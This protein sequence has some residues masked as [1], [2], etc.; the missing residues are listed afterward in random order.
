MDLNNAFIY[1]PFA[2]ERDF[3]AL[4]SLLHNVELID[5]SN[6]DVSEAT[7]REQLTWTGHNPALDR[8]VAYF[9]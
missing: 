7:L 8:W 1:R 3:A 2:V 4:V 6:E 9:M 5:Q